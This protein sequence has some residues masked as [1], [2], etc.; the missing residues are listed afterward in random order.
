MP[1]KILLFL[2]NNFI[3]NKKSL[4]QNAKGLELAGSPGRTIIELFV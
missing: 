3:K 1:L 2:K 4:Q